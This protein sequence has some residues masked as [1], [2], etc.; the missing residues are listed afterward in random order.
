M[1]DK[2]N[3]T[4]RLLLKAAP[5]AMLGGAAFASAPRAE[6]TA[7]AVQAATSSV[8]DRPRVVFDDAVLALALLAE[9]EIAKAY[10]SGGIFGPLGRTHWQSAMRCLAGMAALP[11]GSTEAIAAKDRLAGMRWPAGFGG[12]YTISD[13][14]ALPLLASAAFDKAELEGIP[15]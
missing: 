7:L 9:E 6:L 4:R 3:S 8:H 15:A 2:M 13:E 12:D 5:V 1:A 11:A 10:E 14:F